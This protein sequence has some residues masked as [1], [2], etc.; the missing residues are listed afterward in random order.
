MVKN[1]WESHPDYKELSKALFAV[2]DAA[3]HGFI[4]FLVF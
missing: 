2:R 1:T 3:V 4:Y